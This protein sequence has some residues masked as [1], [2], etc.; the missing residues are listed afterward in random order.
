MN[1]RGR[2]DRRRSRSGSR[3][4]DRRRKE[5]RSPGYSPV[6]GD[7]SLSEGEKSRSK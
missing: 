5:R 3:D 2:N 6:K 7:D 4:K 1:R